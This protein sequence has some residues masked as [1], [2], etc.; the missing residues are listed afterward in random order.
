[1]LIAEKLSKQQLHEYQEM[2]EEGFED[3]FVA[4]E[5]RPL[6][7]E[8]IYKARCIKIE[9]GIYHGTV[10]IYL[11]FQITEPYEHEGTKLFMAMNAFKKVPPGAKYYQQ[12]VIA[13]EGINS[14]RDDRMTPLIFKNGIFEVVVRTAIPKNKYASKY[15]VIDSL[16][17]KII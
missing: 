3:Y 4:G 2:E 6:I 14:L 11:R 5:A 16:K 10:K 1:M 7:P 13:N 8:G 17:C 15:S 12:W 9:K